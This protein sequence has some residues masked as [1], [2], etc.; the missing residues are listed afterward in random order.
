LP[1]EKLEKIT[2]GIISLA[3]VPRYATELLAG[4]VRGR[5]VVGVRA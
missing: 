2:P 1:A 3:D 4:N 5:I